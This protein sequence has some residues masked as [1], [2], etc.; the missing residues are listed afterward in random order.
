M[1]NT[2][3]R[4]LLGVL[5]LVQALIRLCFMTVVLHADMDEALQL[6]EASKE[7]LHD[8]DGEDMVRAMVQAAP[9]QT[10]L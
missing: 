10:V 1:P 5:Q 4:T 8:D 9:T 2:I 3:V 7:S 6:M